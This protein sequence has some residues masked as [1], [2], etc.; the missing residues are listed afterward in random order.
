MTSGRWTV[1]RLAPVS[2]LAAAALLLFAACGEQEKARPF[3]PVSTPQA[4]SGKGVLTGTINLVAAC[5]APPT[6]LLFIQPS[7]RGD[8]VFQ[9]QYLPGGNYEVQLD[10]GSYLVTAQALSCVYSENFDIIA[11]ES[12]V[13]S[14]VLQ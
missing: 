2:A 5:G 1:P 8:I 13:V 11:G 9:Q 10:P 7:G 6:V 4:Q 3:V 12:V 14:P